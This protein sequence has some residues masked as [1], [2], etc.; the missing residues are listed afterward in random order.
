MNLRSWSLVV[1]VLVIFA[2]IIVSAATSAVGV[3]TDKEWTLPARFAGQGAFTIGCALW[4]YT[5]ETPYSEDNPNTGTIVLQIAGDKENPAELVAFIDGPR[6]SRMIEGSHCAISVDWSAIPTE[7]RP[8]P[9][10]KTG[11]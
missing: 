3:K 11:N 7:Q 2:A 5:S 4:G 1:G 9:S 10:D 8:V 6:G